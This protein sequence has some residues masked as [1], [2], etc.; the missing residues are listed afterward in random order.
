[1]L[2][3][4]QITIL[5]HSCAYA[6]PFI[7]YRNTNDIMPLRRRT[8]YPHGVDAG[9]DVTAGEMIEA[10]KD[11]RA[12]KAKKTKLSVDELDAVAGGAIWD[13]EDAPDGHEMDVL[14]H[15]IIMIIRRIPEYGVRK[16]IIVSRVIIKISRQ[17]I[18]ADL[19]CRYVDDVLKFEGDK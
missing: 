12:E 3:F 18:R 19:Y 5:A 14:H 2:Q 6:V 1:M 10:E 13:G 11:F 7:I 16:A 17:G 15:I 9:Y 4:R 8:V